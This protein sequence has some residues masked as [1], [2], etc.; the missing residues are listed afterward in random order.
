MP[1]EDPRLAGRPH[2][3]GGL[4]DRPRQE[5][6]GQLDRHRRVKL[7]DSAVGDKGVE[8]TALLTPRD[9]LPWGKREQSPN[10]LRMSVPE[11]GVPG[12]SS[13]SRNRNGLNEGTL[14]PHD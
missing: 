12:P 11:L 7:W 14:P 1:N 2:E 9:V 8:G 6:V 13:T 10:Q 3:S 4:K 5:T